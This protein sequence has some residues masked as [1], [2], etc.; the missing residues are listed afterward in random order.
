MD[1]LVSL[2]YEIK[3]TLEHINGK[4]SEITLDYIKSFRGAISSRPQNEVD[5]VANGIQQFYDKIIKSAKI[6]I[7]EF[8]FMRIKCDYCN[9]ILIPNT[10][11][12]TNANDLRPD[13]E[14]IK[15]LLINDRNGLIEAKKNMLEALKLIPTFALRDTIL[16]YQEMSI[17]YDGSQKSKDALDIKWKEINTSIVKIQKNAMSQKIPEARNKFYAAL[18]AVHNRVKFLPDIILDYFTEKPNRLW[19]KTIYM[20]E[21]TELEITKNKFRQIIKTFNEF[22]MNVTNASKKKK[23][24]NNQIHWIETETKLF[25]ADIGFLDLMKIEI[26]RLPAETIKHEIEFLKENPWT[27]QEI[28]NRFCTELNNLLEYFTPIQRKIPDGFINCFDFNIEFFDLIRD[29]VRNLGSSGE[30]NLQNIIQNVIRIATKDN[31]ILFKK[32]KQ[33]ISPFLKISHDILHELMEMRRMIQSKNEID[34]ELNKIAT[35]EL[36]DEFRKKINL[37]IV[38]SSWAIRARHREAFNKWNELK[39]NNI[40]FSQFDLHIDEINQAHIKMRMEMLDEFPLKRRH[41]LRCIF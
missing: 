7:D 38:Q 28:V 13:L 16:Q 41:S 31:N 10:K 29:R 33:Q 9:Q 1:E 34:E 19:T 24:T 14:R 5:S 4:I 20:Y 11:N 6:Q 2:I 23:A 30:A 12:F 8:D 17:G 32:L 21:A 36:K 22:G 3:I 37:R 27:K 26:S 18:L 40:I 15:S 35:V 25:E 39:S